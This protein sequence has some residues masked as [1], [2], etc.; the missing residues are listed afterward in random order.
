[1][2]RL[3][4]AASDI[5]ARQRWMGVLARASAAEIGALLQAGPALPAHTRLR[6]PEAGLVMVRGR[7]GGG[8]AAFNLGEMSVTRCTVRD[9][10]GRIGHAYSAGRDAA[11]AELSARLDAALQDAALHDA[12]AAA[13]I[14]P[15]ARTQAARREA[16]A[17]RAAATRV[18]FFTLATM[19]SAG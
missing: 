15:L 9:E 6:G 13:V 18:Q 8:G 16:D 2:A 4:P 17:R 5:A 10:A 3:S 1:M 14:D 7:E 12:I 19:R 11:Q